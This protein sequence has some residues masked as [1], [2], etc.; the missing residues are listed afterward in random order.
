RIGV[1]NTARGAAVPCGTPDRVSDPGGVDE[2]LRLDAPDV[3]AGATE[4]A[5]LA[6]R[7]PLR[8]VLL[9]ENAVARTGSDDRD[10]IS[11]HAVTLSRTLLMLRCYWFRG[12]VPA[13]GP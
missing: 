7:R 9:I 5:L 2:T 11:L 10:V 12:T 6:D 3:Q 1:A 8:R 4:G 13:P